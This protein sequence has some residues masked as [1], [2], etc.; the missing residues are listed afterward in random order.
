MPKA[1]SGVAGGPKSS[2]GGITWDLSDLYAAVGDP[3]LT[4]DEQTALQEAQA[5]AAEYRGQ[6]NVP[7]GPSPE[8]MAAALSRYEAL[9]DQASRPSCFSGLLHAGDTGKHEYGALLAHTQEAATTVQTTLMFFDLEWIAL[10]DEAAAPVIASPLC[11]R[12]RHYL[13]SIRRYKPHTLSEPEEIILAEKVNTSSAAFVRLFDE[14]TARTEF[15]I[16]IKGR[17]KKLNQSET[18]ALLYQ[19]DRDVRKAAAEGFTTGL[20]ANTHTAAFILNTLLQDHAVTNRLRHYAGPADSR[21]LSNEIDPASVTA[22]L[23]ACEANAWIV[24]DYYRLKGKLLGLEPL[25]DYDRYAPV[26]IQGASIPTRDWPSARESVQAAYDTFSPELGR[27]VREFFEKR[28]IDAEL[29]P[30]KHGGAFSHSAVPS[31]HPFILMNYT[32]KLRDVMTLAHELGHGVHQYLSR[33]QGILQAGTPLTLAETASVF[34]EMLTFERL[35]NEQNDP[36]VQLSLLCGKLEDIFATVFRQVVM[37]RFEEKIHAGRAQGELSA[38]DYD[39]LWMEANAPMFD[40]AVVLTEDYSRWWSYISHF[41]HSPFYCYAYSFG[42]LLVL[43]LWAKYKQE[44]A[45]FVPQ[46][47]ELL[48]AGGSDTPANLVGRMGLNINDPGFWNSG[49]SILGDMVK[50]AGKL[51]EEIR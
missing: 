2:A 11:A 48:S 18:L 28:W 20:K 26:T 21:H 45:A 5:F 19:P 14:A 38:E 34:G 32:D 10:A 29:R 12:W 16:K 36:R 3:K 47:V 25:Y 30:A 4:G 50:K 23:G 44:G 41:Y 9:L 17:K 6:I 27:I 40:G 15:E 7:A 39:R 49:L 42:E 43:A 46:Y 24:R 8:L 22:L 1:K 51:A 33:P 31:T 37:T 13:H 35:M